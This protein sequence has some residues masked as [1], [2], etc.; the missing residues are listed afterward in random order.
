[1]ADE[2]FLRPRLAALYDPLDPDR[3]DLEPY[4][5]LAEE[6]GARRVLDIGCGTG[7][8]ALLL[9]DRGIEALG[10]DPERATLDGPRATPGGDRV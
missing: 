9:A 1:M 6:S 5:R 7:V 10:G 8:F 2:N 4:V 3:G